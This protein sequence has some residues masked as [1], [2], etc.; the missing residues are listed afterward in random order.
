[1]KHIYHWQLLAHI[2]FLQAT[3]DNTIIFWSICNMNLFISLFSFSFFLRSKGG[4]RVCQ[5]RPIQK[6][7]LYHLSYYYVLMLISF[8]LWLLMHSRCCFF[9][10]LIL[11]VCL[12][13]VLNLID[14]TN[15]C[16][17][18]F[19]NASIFVLSLHIL[20]WKLQYRTWLWLRHHWIWGIS[21]S[22][23]KIIH[24]VLGTQI[25]T[26]VHETIPSNILV[27]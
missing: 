9:F 6:M 4:A 24:S 27:K 7:E 13:K 1:M 16:W 17:V 11:Y 20:R 19:M 26:N 18:I 15:L 3:A 14:A 2:L 21:L 12:F 22:E 25:L 23:G 5:K 8:L 10:F